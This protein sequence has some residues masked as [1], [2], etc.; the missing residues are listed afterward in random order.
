MNRLFIIGNG[1]DLAHGLKTKYSDFKEYLKNTGQHDIVS[2]IDKHVSKDTKDTKDTKE[3]NSLESDMGQYVR[4]GNYEEVSKMCD[5]ITKMRKYLR[6]WILSINTSSVSPALKPEIMSTGDIYLS[7]NY[8][9][10]LEQFGI[11]ENQILY[12]H[13]KAKDTSKELIF[14]HNTYVNNLSNVS[15]NNQLLEVIDKKIGECN[16]LTRKYA[17]HNIM[18]NRDFFESLSDITEIV[19]LGHSFSDVDFPYFVE[20]KKRVS[21]NCKWYVSYYYNSEKIDRRSKMRKLCVENP[22]LFDTSQGIM[23]EIVDEIIESQI[24]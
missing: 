10:T 11:P 3:W 14:G 16:I 19:V 7:F 5:V 18:V 12:I 23:K 6:E 4:Y 20:I 8:T 9:D 1:F 24:T 22:T 13:G 21:D 17:D 2:I 15:N